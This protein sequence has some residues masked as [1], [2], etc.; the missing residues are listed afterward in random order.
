MTE[1]VRFHF[2]P[3]CPWAWLTSRWL[4]EVRTVRDVD[5]DWA[6]FSL[7]EVNRGIDDEAM[8]KGHAMSLDALRTLV[9]VRRE[10]GNAAVG[11]LYRELGEAR[12]DRSQDLGDHDV[13]RAALRGAGLEEALVDKAVADPTTEAEL[14]AEHAAVVT[15]FQAFGVPT[16][17]LDGGAGPAMFGPV[18]QTV[19]CGEEAGQV[20]DHAVWLTRQPYFYE[21]KRER[22]ARP[23]TG[24]YRDSD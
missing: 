24:R 1:H 7:A 23:D 5:V 6:L 15:D 16:L 22:T 12:H 2:D 13:L 3:V 19:P 20:W 17:V 14:L 18:V 21:L 11:R 4:E 8:A 10:H 9:L